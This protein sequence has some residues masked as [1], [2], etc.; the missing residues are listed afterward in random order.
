[1]SIKILAPA[2]I[3]IGLRVFE[4]SF[5]SVYH[6]L[7]SIFQTIDFCDELEVE[8]I[9]SSS[10]ECEF[11]CDSMVL[12]E[13]NTITKT[14]D[15]FAKITGKNKSVRVKLTKRIPSGGGLG[16]GSSD[17]ASFL[18]ALAKLND[19][20]LT[21]NLAKSVA[22]E[23]GSDVFFFLGLKNGF[24]AALVSGRGEVVQEIASRKLY[25]VLILPDVFSSTKEAYGLLD[26]F[27]ES[28]KSNSGFDKFSSEY[29]DYSKYEENYRGDI[30]NWNFVNSFTSVL[31]GKYGIIGEAI[32]DLKK[33]GASFSDMSGSGSTVFGVFE[34]FDSATK[35]V[36]SLK[37]KWN[38]VLA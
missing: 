20:E 13:I 27:Y 32:S 24:G 33:V 25:F 6:N 10:G 23:V 37:S 31:V 11:L 28:L 14:F 26:E 5:D 18:R 7:E 8:F 30:R 9:D 16:G 17:S 36:S 15:S 35:A 2:K 38:C 4:K 22:S 3:N 34:D 29:L 19:V 1:M 21:E 12:P